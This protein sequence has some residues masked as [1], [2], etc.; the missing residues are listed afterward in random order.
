MYF[1]SSANFFVVTLFTSALHVSAFGSS[2][3]ATL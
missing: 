1:P 3:G 2:S